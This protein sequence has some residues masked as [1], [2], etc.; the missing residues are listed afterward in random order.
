MKVYQRL[1]QRGIYTQE[2]LNKALFSVAHCKNKIEKEEAEWECILN[3]A[4]NHN[5][6]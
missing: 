5:F 2:D 3:W 4:S 1:L 6:I